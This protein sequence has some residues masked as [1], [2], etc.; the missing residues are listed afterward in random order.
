MNSD[1]KKQFTIIQNHCVKTA[2]FKFMIMCYICIFLVLLY[3]FINVFYLTWLHVLRYLC[4][5]ITWFKFLWFTIYFYFLFFIQTY[6]DDFVRFWY[7]NLVCGCG[8]ASLSRA[9]VGLISSDH[10]L[11]NISLSNHFVSLLLFSR[12]VILVSKDVVVAAGVLM[13]FHIKSHIKH[14]S[15]LFIRAATQLQTIIWTN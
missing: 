10:F 7:L 11:C 13:I 4:W 1:L 12:A 9:D 5:N 14:T 6:P 3:N 15:R 2:S 8:L